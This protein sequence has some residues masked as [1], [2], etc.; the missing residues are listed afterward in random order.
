MPF[1]CNTF[2]SKVTIELAGS[3]GAPVYRNLRWPIAKRE[4]KVFFDVI[5]NKE[6]EKKM[7]TWRMKSTP[8]KLVINPTDILDWANIWSSLGG[9]IPKFVKTDNKDDSDIRVL[10]STSGNLVTSFL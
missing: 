3:A 10:L 8:L 6:G 2:S 4:L 7:P 9:S 5:P 1:I